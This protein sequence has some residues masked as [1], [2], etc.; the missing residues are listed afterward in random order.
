MINDSHHAINKHNT[1]HPFKHFKNILLRGT[2]EHFSYFFSL[3]F[4]PSF[5]LFFRGPV[6]F[7]GPMKKMYEASTE[8]KKK[9]KFQWQHANQPNQRHE[10]RERKGDFVYVCR[11]KANNG[12]F[13]FSPLYL[14]TP[15]KRVEARIFKIGWK[16]KW[17]NP[18]IKQKSSGEKKPWTGKEIWLDNRSN[19]IED[20][21]MMYERRIGASIMFLW[22]MAVASTRII[23]YSGIISAL[24]FSATSSSSLLGAFLSFFRCLEAFVYSNLMFRF[25]FQTHI[26]CD[27]WSKRNHHSKRIKALKNHGRRSEQHEKYYDW[28]E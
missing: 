4:S 25:V 22:S 11:W 15:F 18:S 21:N 24:F 28:N 16:W 19:L 13:S 26:H 12:E 3:S 14:R 2:S 6:L 20:Q 17:R 8:E 27:V 7:G 23:N 10:N 5:S 1:H 9:S